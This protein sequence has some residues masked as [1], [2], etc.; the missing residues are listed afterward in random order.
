MNRLSVAATISLVLMVVATAAY[1][2]WP[3]VAGAMGIKPPAPQPAYA[4]G[5]TFDAPREWYS[6]A[7]RTLVIFARASC[8][9]CEKAQPFLKELVGTLGDNAAA[10]MAH[11]P[12]A[13]DDDAQ[14]ARSLGISDD[15]IVVV[16]NTLRVRSTP[17]IVLVDQS[18]TILHAWEG[19]GPP[20]NHPKIAAAIKAALQ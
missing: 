3:R 10:V 13:P 6:G 14:F 8:G 20:E 5:Q 11:P 16:G 2:G 17:T 7:P 12:G 9:A 19:V 15:H 1:V 4:A 18:G